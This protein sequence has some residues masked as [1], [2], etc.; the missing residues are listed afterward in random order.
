MWKCHPVGHLCKDHRL[1]VIIT[2]WLKV[3]LTN[4]YLKPNWFG[5]FFT[6]KLDG[7]LN[8][9]AYIKSYVL[10]YTMQAFLRKKHIDSYKSHLSRSVRKHNTSSHLS[11]FSY[12]LVFC[13]HVLGVFMGF[14][15]MEVVFSHQLIT[16]QLKNKRSYC[17]WLRVGLSYTHTHTHTHTQRANSGQNEACT[18]GFMHTDSW[19]VLGGICALWRIYMYDMSFFSLFPK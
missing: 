18:F 15:T 8:S 2:V 17:V 19:W 10:I 6:L 9:S 12:F 4:L 11:V 14:S 3:S 13:C 16:C 5:L 1:G 7:K